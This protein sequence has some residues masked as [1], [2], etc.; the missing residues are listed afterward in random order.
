MTAPDPGEQLRAPLSAWLSAPVID[1][2]RPNGGYSAETWLVDVARDSADDIGDYRVV[3]RLET[4]EPAVYPQQAPGLDV[5]VDIQYRVMNALTRDGRVPVAPLLGYEA[6]P[7]VLGQPFFVM[8][9]VDGDVPGESPPYTTDGFFTTLPPER[10]RTMIEHGIEVLAA[11]HAVDWEAHGLSWLVPPGTVPSVDAQLD[12]WRRFS[13]RELAGR[14]H[15]AIAEGWRRLAA[16]V[17]RVHAPVLNWGD[18]RPGN[19][20]WRDGRCVCVTDF[21]AASIAPPELDLGWWLMFD[22]SMHEVVGADR[23][24]GEPTRDEQRDLYARASGGDIDDTWWFETFAAVKY[25][26]IVVRVMNRLVDRGDLPADQTI[27][28]NNPA[29]DGLVQLLDAT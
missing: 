10:R 22:R 15:P 7:A 8:G 24:A 28:L 14:D 26:A 23:L 11:V 20:I 16:D 25:A 1:L 6:D 29:V 3:L 9:F 17:P 4:P 27:W 18:P 13:D 5:E 2:R 19:M 21:E 12:V